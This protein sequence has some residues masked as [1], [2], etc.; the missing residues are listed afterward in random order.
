MGNAGAGGI[1]CV[2]AALMLESPWGRMALTRG[3]S[4]APSMRKPWLV[5]ADVKAETLQI[6]RF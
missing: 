5:S 4:W 2:S 6:F 3:G 1:Q